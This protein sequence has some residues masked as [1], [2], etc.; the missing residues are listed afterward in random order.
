[1][2]IVIIGSGNVAVVMGIKALA[3]GH[4]IVQ[5]VG[6]RAEAVAP[7]GGEWNCGYTTRWEEIDR[8]A[9]L[10][11]VALSDRALPGLGRLLSLPDR[12]VVHT[13]GAVPVAVLA[14]VS[15][16]CGVLYPLQSLRGDVR[17]IP[18][19]PLL[20]DAL[21]QEDLPP[22]EGFARSLARQVE[23]ADDATRLKCHVAGILVN[24]FT[25]YLYTLAEEFCRKEGIDFAILLPII[26]E[27]ASRLRY[28]S[29]RDVQTGPAVRGDQG[30]VERHLGVLA[31]YDHIRE[32]YRMFTDQIGE[33]YGTAQNK[34]HGKGN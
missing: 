18:E 15:A 21:R 9:E 31:D 1:M 8:Q 22:I 34:T 12:L 19:F 17:P 23:R 10:Y 26:M 5:V 2:K 30:T 6:R 25:N 33:F 24:N 3:A 4:S 27:T 14:D 20:I 32:L 16:R 13:A 29:P 7:L 28:N 11:I